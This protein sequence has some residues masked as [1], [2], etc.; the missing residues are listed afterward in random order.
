MNQQHIFK[1]CI[2]LCL[3]I[4][5]VDGFAQQ[6]NSETEIDTIRYKT[7]YGLRLG[8]D[9]SKPIRGT[10]QDF[11]SGFE[12][13]ADYRLSKKW[14]AAVE[15]GTEEQNTVEDFTNSTAKGEYI[16]L[17]VNYNS[18]KN[19]LD[20]NNEIYIGFRYGFAT[21]EQ[22]LNSY[23]INTGSSPFDSQT[24]TTPVTED[25]LTAHWGEVQ[26]GIKAEI[27]NNIF[28]GISGSYKLMI[29]V[30]DPENFKTHFAPGFNRVYASNTGFGFNYTISYLI[31]FKKK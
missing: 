10:I 31:P 20:M 18:Y 5:F 13:V 27:F 26:V 9:V 24:I 17:G 15:L 16:R 4:C 25:G 8:V 14:Y 6:N 12:V 30:E 23:E 1:F 7:S 2:S 29:S 22:T 28:L 21:F 11:Y 19:W 3:W